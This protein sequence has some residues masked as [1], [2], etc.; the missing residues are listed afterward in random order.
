M[1]SNYVAENVSRM[2][3]QHE[4]FGWENLKGK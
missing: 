4:T 2:G 3:E 1:K